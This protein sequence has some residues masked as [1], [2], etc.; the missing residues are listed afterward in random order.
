MCPSPERPIILK[1]QSQKKLRKGNW[2]SIYRIRKAKHLSTH[3]GSERG[4]GRS[5]GE[6][7]NALGYSFKK[8]TKSLTNGD[9][10]IKGLWANLEQFAKICQCVSTWQWPHGHWCQDRWRWTLCYFFLF[11]FIFL[12]FSFSFNFLFLE[13]LGLGVISHAVTSVT[14]LMAWSRDQSRDLGEGSGRN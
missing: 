1:I 5:W 10:S 13:Q 6:K 2:E 3:G 4:G 12:F 7:A 11:I 8:S 14:K 9:G